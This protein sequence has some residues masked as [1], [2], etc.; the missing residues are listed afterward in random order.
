MTLIAYSINNTIPVLSG[1][2]LVTLKDSKKG[3]PQIDLPFHLTSLADLTPDAPDSTPIGLMQKIYVVHDTLAV[4]FAGSLYEMKNFYED[5]VNNFKYFSVSYDKVKEFVDNYPSHEISELRFVILGIEMNTKSLFRVQSNGWAI[6]TSNYFGE[7]RATG[8]GLQS[9]FEEI[10][11]FSIRN[12]SDKSQ[13]TSG[14][15]FAKNMYLIGN[16]IAKEKISLYSIAQRWGAGFE[17]IRFNGQKFEKFDNLTYILCRTIVN[18]DGSY[19]NNPFLVSNFKYESEYLIISSYD[20]A[21]MKYFVVPPLLRKTDIPS[22]NRSFTHDT[23]NC[24]RVMVVYIVER[25]DKHYLLGSIFRI[26]E[27]DSKP[28]IGFRFDL[29]EGKAGV[30]VDKELEQSVFSNV[31]DWL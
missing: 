7:C 30:F 24:D 1:D 19:T 8:S 29:G 14:D 17:M 2:L 28:K 20:F 16:F 26:Q 10:A 23:F 9:Y 25:N 31:A 18:S 4:G 5:F 27:G 22:G 15:V 21:E 11:K 3:Y 6:T 13:N 12:E